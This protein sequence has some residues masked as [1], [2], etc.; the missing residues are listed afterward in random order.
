MS[1]TIKIMTL[2]IGNPSILRAE[3][4]IEWLQNRDEDIFV[5]TETKNSAGC[6]LIEAVFSGQRL[7]YP[8][9]NF[10]VV[11]P[12]SSTNDLGVMCLSKF[13]IQSTQYAFENSNQYY[14]RYIHN[15]ICL[16]EQILKTISLYVPSRNQTP[17]KILR[18]K[19]FIEETIL[20][21]KNLKHTP[22]IICGDFNIISHDHIPRYKTFKSWEY[23]FYD[24]LIELG[25]VDAFKKCHPEAQEYSWVGRTNDGYRYDYCFVSADIQDR[26]VD[27]YFIH[28]TRK[29]KLTDHSALV[30]EL[31]L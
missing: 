15:E 28:D 27:C 23:L 11:F 16:P 3:K 20:S 30:L 25:Y 22:T 21:I 12:K 17:E 13:P 5:L 1:N 8:P 7:D 4:Q 14:C 24:Q 2:N 10:D 29:I 26:I 9:F 6:S 18:K 31:S 19:T